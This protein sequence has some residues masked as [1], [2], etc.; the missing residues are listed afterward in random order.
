MFFFLMKFHVLGQAC[1]PHLTGSCP[2]V[3]CLGV[4]DWGQLGRNTAGLGEVSCLY[5]IDCLYCIEKEIITR[6]V[7][8]LYKIY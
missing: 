2:D 3:Y 8:T 7:T 5:C 1:L 6:L 4:G